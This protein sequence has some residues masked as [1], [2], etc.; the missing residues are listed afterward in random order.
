M[1]SKIKVG[2]NPTLEMR[3][4]LL[5]LL[6]LAATIFAGCSENIELPGDESIQTYKIEYVT[7]METNFI[8]VL[9]VKLTGESAILKVAMTNPS[10]NV[11]TKTISMDDFEGDIASVSFRMSEPGDVPLGGEY[12]IEVLNESGTIASKNI[13]LEKPKFEITD[14]KFNITGD[15]IHGIWITIE[16]KGDMPGYVQ[17]A[18]IVVDGGNPKGWY[19]YE[20]FEPKQSKT[21]GVDEDFTIKEDGSELIVWI[22]YKAQLQGEYRTTVYPN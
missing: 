16:N 13:K 20:A 19:F 3:L 2:I 7:K 22:Y 6:I 18:N 15:T 17:Q 5:L 1:R 12:K 10:A 9:D 14:A 21:I 8:P 11:T 4:K